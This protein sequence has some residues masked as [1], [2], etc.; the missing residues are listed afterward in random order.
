MNILENLKEFKD[1]SISK[2]LIVTTFILIVLG[3][4]RELI[5]DVYSE[6]LK[7]L[8]HFSQKTDFETWKS[9]FPI[10]QIISGSI[11]LA[12]C[13]FFIIQMVAFYRIWE[14]TK[15]SAPNLYEK[16]QQS[17]SNTANYLVVSAVGYF[18]VIGYYDILKIE[19][20]KSDF[21]TGVSL[22]LIILGAMIRFTLYFYY[23]KD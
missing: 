8:T 12:L 13:M 4:I 17:Y 23:N 20:L 5:P 9:I 21:L 3:F 6:F 10:I 22:I 11:V 19:Y 2:L 7:T 14:K 15:D 16:R 18:N 1:L